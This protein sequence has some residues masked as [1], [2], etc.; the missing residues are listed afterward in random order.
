MSEK[1]NNQSQAVNSF[2]GKAIES[3]LLDTVKA[4]IQ[5]F[6]HDVNFSSHEIAMSLYSVYRGENAEMMS[7]LFSKGAELETYQI[8][9]VI[10]ESPLPTFKVIFTHYLDWY[11]RSSMNGRF[12]QAKAIKNKRFELIPFIAKKGFEL[13]P[14]TFP[15]SDCIGLSVRHDSEVQAYALKHISYSMTDFNALDDDTK[16]R[17]V[18]ELG[19]ADESLIDALLDSSLSEIINADE[20]HKHALKNNNEYLLGKILSTRKNFSTDSIECDSTK[21]MTNPQAFEVAVQ[22]DPQ[23]S[24]LYSK[25]GRGHYYSDRQIGLVLATSNPEILAIAIEHIARLSQLKKGNVE[26]ADITLILKQAFGNIDDT[27][28]LQQ[29]FSLLPDDLFSGNDILERVVTFVLPNAE[30]EDITP[31]LRA[32]QEKGAILSKEFFYEVL[33][34]RIDL[35]HTHYKEARTEHLHLHQLIKLAVTMHGEAIYDRIHTLSKYYDK[36]DKQILASFRQ[37]FY[38]EN[39]SVNAS[40]IMMLFVAASEEQRCAFLDAMT[41]TDNLNKD[42]AF[43]EA[44]KAWGYDPITIMSLPIK[45]KI[46]SNIVSALSA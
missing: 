34:D 40:I 21:F 18:F 13:T 29:F 46:K 22:C 20:L 8:S 44:M 26:R 41:Y 17:F 12:P 24:Y 43:Q 7:Y 45:D 4:L 37:A 23:S 11:K 31:F 1:F 35:I 6:P 3:D 16:E 19:S 27:E 38:S 42:I 25:D 36:S 9:K 28:V 33:Q 5:A 30:V 15:L 14:E 39:N 10:D 32:A 2:V